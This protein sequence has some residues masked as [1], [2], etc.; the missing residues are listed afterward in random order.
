MNVNNDYA[1][2]NYFFSFSLS[3]NRPLNLPKMDFRFFREPTF[4]SLEGEPLIEDDRD[5]V[6]DDGNT[7]RTLLAGVAG[8]LGAGVT[9]GVAGDGA[10]AEL[11]VGAAP[12]VAG[13]AGFS[14][15]GIG[16]AAGLV[17]AAS[18]GG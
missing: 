16:V 15:S 3:P 13:V 9:A 14:D 17:G 7:C 8:A 2:Y 4:P 5:S 12:L 1:P 11:D 10:S 6:S 18:A